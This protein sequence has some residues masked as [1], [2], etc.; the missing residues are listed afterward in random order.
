MFESLAPIPIVDVR[1]GGPV[2]HAVEGRA[3]ARAL[4]EEALAWF[5]RGMLAL[6]PALDGVARRWLTRS[7][8][9]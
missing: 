9:P 2:R 7:H 8:G 1:D 4:R 5:P 3:R 6:T